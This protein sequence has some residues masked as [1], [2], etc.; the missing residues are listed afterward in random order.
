[1]S[2]QYIERFN[3]MDSVTFKACGG[4]KYIKVKYFQTNLIQTTMMTEQEDISGRYKWF[5]SLFC[6]KN[7]G[8]YI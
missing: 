3:H 2:N 4:R 7:D 5:N 8:R 1:M 6:R